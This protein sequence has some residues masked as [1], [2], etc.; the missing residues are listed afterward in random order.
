MS[1]LRKSSELDFNLSWTAGGKHVKGGRRGMPE[2]GTQLLRIELVT[3]AYAR[4]RS[5]TR[6]PPLQRRNTM[7]T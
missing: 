3:D 4:V 7:C 2:H 5:R 1:G 6:R